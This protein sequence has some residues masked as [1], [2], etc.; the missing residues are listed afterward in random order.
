M[1][2]EALHQKAQEIAARSY[3][4]GTLYLNTL[5]QVVEELVP[6]LTRHEI[7]CLLRSLSQALMAL[8]EKNE[9]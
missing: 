1:T 9:P 5:D 2:T 4:N 6:Q 7:K 8:K 3:K